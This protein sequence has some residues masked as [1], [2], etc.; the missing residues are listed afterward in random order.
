MTNDGAPPN[1]PNAPDWSAPWH[2]ALRDLAPVAWARWA[3][4]GAVALALSALGGAPVRFVPQSALPAGVAYEAYIH[5]QR[6]VPTRDN[7]HDFFNGLIWLR[8]PRTK[9]RLNALQA[10]EL[11]RNGVAATRGPVRDAATLFDENAL[12][13]HAPDALWDALAA[14][15]WLA[16][17]GDLRPLWQQA[18]ALVFGHAALEKLARPYKAIT[19]HVWRV[20]PAFDP[21]GDLRALDAWLASDLTAGKLA[22][23]PFAALPVLGI[24]GWWPANETPAFYDDAAVFRPQRN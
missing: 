24:P 21:A 10:A 9:S 23:K 3:A 14:R 13:L 4:G 6:A 16:L 1:V 15:R 18:N 17:F 8:F 5:A 20:A 2:A 22:A 11:G 7:L 12:L 19:C